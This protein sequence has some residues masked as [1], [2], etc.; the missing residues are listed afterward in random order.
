MEDNHQSIII[1]KPEYLYWSKWLNKKYQILTFSF[2][3]ELKKSFYKIAEIH[4]EYGL[5]A[6][7]NIIVSGPLSYIKTRID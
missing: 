1:G 4:Q 7:F 5:K 6:C 2:D 3:G